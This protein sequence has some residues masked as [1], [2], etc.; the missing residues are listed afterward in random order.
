MGKSIIGKKFLWKPK[1]WIDGQWVKNENVKG[2]PVTVVDDRPNVFN[3]IEV[4]KDFFTDE[5]KKTYHIN[6][7]MAAVDDLQIIK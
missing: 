7:F 2:I 5:D 3:E 4:S 1:M 6:R